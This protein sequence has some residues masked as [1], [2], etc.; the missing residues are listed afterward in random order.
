MLEPSGRFSV[1]S[2]FL[3]L[4][5]LALPASAVL[6]SSNWHCLWHLKLQ[7]DLKLFIWKC[8]ASALP[9]RGPLGQWL[10]LDPDRASCPLCSSHI[11][12]GVNL[13]LSCRVARVAWRESPC[14]LLSDAFRVSS[15]PEFIKRLLQA[16]RSLPLSVL[17]F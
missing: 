10:H 14:P 11:E 4:K 5:P 1:K 16:E 8:A 2:A 12:S 13:F 15:L 7:D 6:S 3:L 9:V 17:E